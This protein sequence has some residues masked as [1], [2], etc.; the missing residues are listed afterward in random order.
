MN[1][2]A[3]PT[4]TSSLQPSPSSSYSPNTAPK[5]P[6]PNTDGDRGEIVK[7]CVITGVVTCIITLIVAG[8]I[9]ITL[10]CLVKK[11]SHVVYAKLLEH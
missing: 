8:A 1:S 3:V 4:A 10:Y 2:T 7:W 6:V 9:G 5:T 11:R